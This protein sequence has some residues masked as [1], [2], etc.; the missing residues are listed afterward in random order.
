M[1]LVLILL[2]SIAGATLLQI[3]SHTMLAQNL[4]NLLHIPLFAVLSLVFIRLFSGVFQKPLALYLTVVIIA[5]LAGALIEVLQGFTG[6]PFSGTD[7][8]RDMIGTGIGIVVHA[9]LVKRLTWPAVMIIILALMAKDSYQFALMLQHYHARNAAF[10][11]LLD[12]NAAWSATFSGLRLAERNRDLVIYK[13]GAYPGLSVLE[14][15]PDWR[16]YRALVFVVEN[17]E[18]SPV[19]L[20]LRV[21]DADHNFQHADRFN[22][23][24]RL[25][26]GIN[27]YRIPL[28]AIASSPQQRVLDLSRVGEIIFFIPKVS[29]DTRL[30]FDHIGL[31]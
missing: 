15:Y 27:A 23:A 6:R 4:Q 18:E 14:P 10:P 12:L 22:K 2:L 20:V 8:I 30:R 31:E 19:Q 29:S 25:S 3:P 13:A 16:G 17:L 5:L 28:K 11:L 24:F 1:L 7:I 26:P 9:W 21:H